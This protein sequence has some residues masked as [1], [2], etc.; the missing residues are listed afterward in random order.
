MKSLT[1]SRQTPS[2]QLSGCPL[3]TDAPAPWAITFWMITLR[4][5]PAAGSLGFGVPLLHVIRCLQHFGQKP[6]MSL[7]AFQ[8]FQG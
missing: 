8:G 4:I 5:L 1:L 6:A 2:S 3:I 7:F